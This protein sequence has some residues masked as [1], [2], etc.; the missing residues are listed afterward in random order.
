MT[1]R[2]RNTFKYKGYDVTVEVDTE[3]VSGLSFLM[4][5][6]ECPGKSFYAFAYFDNVDKFIRCNC[7]W[8]VYLRS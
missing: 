8:D 1:D 7:N 3:S 2:E 4:P 5:N 6:R